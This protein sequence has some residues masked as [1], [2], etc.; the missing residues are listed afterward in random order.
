MVQE[1]LKILEQ[2]F[3]E[4][5]IQHGT[6]TNCGVQHIQNPF[7]REITLDQIDFLTK[8]RTIEHPQLSTGTNEEKCVQAL[9]QLFIS[10]L[11]AIAYATPREHPFALQRVLKAILSDRTPSEAS[12]DVPG[13]IHL[14]SSITSFGMVSGPQ[15]VAL[16]WASLVFGVAFP[17]QSGDRRACASA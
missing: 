8:L 2:E 4:L 7:T 9:H 6:F 3:G 13:G 12:C 15:S 10:L 14:L 16:C 5:T 1:L 17:P 11:G